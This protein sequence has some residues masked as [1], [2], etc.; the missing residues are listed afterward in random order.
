MNAHKV[1][2]IGCACLTV[3]LGVRAISVNQ[4][5]GELKLQIRDTEEELEFQAMTLEQLQETEI[6]QGSLEYIEQM[7]REKLG[8]VREND[9]VFKQK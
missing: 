6:S 7:A 2:C 1:I 9:I 5:L 4:A 8:M 3:L